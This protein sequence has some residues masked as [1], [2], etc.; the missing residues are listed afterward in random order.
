MQSAA[1]KARVRAG[2]ELVQLRNLHAAN[3]AL[4]DAASVSHARARNVAFAEV[5]AVE[6]K[7]A[8]LEVKH[9]AEAVRGIICMCSHP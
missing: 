5:A 3:A 8:A 9:A 6:G 7:F 1:D 2:G 4:A